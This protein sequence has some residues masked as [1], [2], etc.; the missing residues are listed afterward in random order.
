M[1]GKAGKLRMIMRFLAMFMAF[2]VVRGPEAPHGRK[3]N[4]TIPFNMG[5]VG[6]RD[7]SEGA[8]ETLRIPYFTSFSGIPNASATPFP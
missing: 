2:S 7:V 3:K 4:P 6:F 1:S 5:R 8:R